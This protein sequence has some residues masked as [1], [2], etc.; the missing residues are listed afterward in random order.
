MYLPNPFRCVSITQIMLIV[1]MMISKVKAKYCLN[2]FKK[3]PKFL[4]RGQ[5]LDFY[6]PGDPFFAICTSLIC[7]LNAATS[8]LWSRRFEPFIFIQIRA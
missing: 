1:H 5:R 6:H 7:L 8:R 3:L 2:T 4:D